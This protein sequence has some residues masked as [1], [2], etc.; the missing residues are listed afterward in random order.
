[1]NDY[2]VLNEFYFLRN[3]HFF[4]EFFPFLIDLFFQNLQI[5]NEHAW[6]SWNNQNGINEIRIK[7]EAVKNSYGDSNDNHITYDAL[8]LIISNRNKFIEHKHINIANILTEDAHQRWLK[9][10]SRVCNWKKSIH[11]CAKKRE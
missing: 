2:W 3:W 8:T 4:T 5:N 11:W 9:G 6:F 10:T 7:E 1:M